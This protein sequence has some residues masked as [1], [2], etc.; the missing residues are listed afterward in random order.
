MLILALG[1]IAVAS[2][3]FA[4]RWP[5][6][7]LLHRFRWP[8]L[9]WGSLAAQIVIIEF[10]ALHD[11]APVLHIL[12]YVAALAFLW[13]NR[14]VRGALI[15]GAGALSNGLTIALNGGTLPARA[16]AV[17]AAGI[18][19][20]EDFANSAVVDDAILPWLGDV[21]A[22]PEPLP[23]ANTFSVGDI[24]IVI[25]VAVAAWSGSR[26]IGQPV[27]ADGGTETTPPA[28]ASD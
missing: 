13:L 11:W 14:E 7:L 12:T 15:V 1:V 2:P 20:G 3:L 17:E 16:A 27:T 24:L 25:G 10:D 23:L 21:F 26:R 28:T 18:D 4:G 9:I 6:G 8:L 19:A 5:A 22:W